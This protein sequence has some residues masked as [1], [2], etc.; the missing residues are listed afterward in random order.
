MNCELTAWNAGNF[1]LDMPIKGTFLHFYN[2]SGFGCLCGVSLWAWFL[3]T[4]AEKHLFL[5]CQ[6]LYNPA[7]Y[8]WA[9]H[10]CY[11][12]WGSLTSGLPWERFLNIQ[13][14]LEFKV[15]RVMNLRCFW[16]CWTVSHPRPQHSLDSKLT[17]SSS[18]CMCHPSAQCSSQCWNTE[19]AVLHELWRSHCAIVLCL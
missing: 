12:M 5:H 18:H 2:G 3:I 1:L 4:L 10:A 17:A 19:A 13:S 15:K 16:L 8:T 6:V 7:S 14:K 11:W 9:M